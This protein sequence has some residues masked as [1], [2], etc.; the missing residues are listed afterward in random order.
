MATKNIKNTKKVFKADITVDLTDAESAYDVY[1]AFAEAKVKKNMS[2]EEVDAFIS[3][4]C[5]HF[6]VCEGPC[7][8]CEPEPKPKKKNIFQRFWSWITGK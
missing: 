6:Y 1:S 4:H 2:T 5:I 7:P 3:N 8:F